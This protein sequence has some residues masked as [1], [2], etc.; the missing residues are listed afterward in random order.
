[1]SCEK[2][3]D[4]MIK[5]FAALPQA[6]KGRFHKTQSTTG[7]DDFQ[8]DRDRIVHS[9]AFR[10]LAH[11]TQV[12]VY[13]EGD[14]YRNRLTHSLEVAQITRAVARML[15]VNEDLAETTALAHDLGHPPFGHAGEDALDLNMK[16]FGGF[17]HNAQS[18]RTV[19][20]LEDRYPM[21]D[22][23]NLTIESLEG[24]LK[25]NGP[26]TDHELPWAITAFPFYKQLDLHLH[27]G[28]E[29]QI[30]AIC[31]DI[32]YNAHDIDDGLRAGM[33]DMAHL[34]ELE[35]CAKIMHGIKKDYPDIRPYPFKHEFIRRLIT[36]FVSDMVDHTQNLLDEY[37][38]ESYDAVRHA[39]FTFVSFSEEG[40][41]NNK[42]LKAYLM[43][44][45]YKHSIV[46]RMT[47]K[48]KRVISD[49]CKIYLAEPEIM[50]MN[51]AKNAQNISDTQRAV[52]I[53]DFIAGMTDKF[54]L[55]EHK[56]LFDL[57]ADNL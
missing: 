47:S 11:K 5:A 27:A 10:R 20:F 21:H 32:A 12:F 15:G 26:I 33:F 29:A 25:H 40:L 45:M 7:R 38:P 57:S 18:L 54:A 1:M 34:M 30:A 52:L 35:F 55:E 16:Q 24:I 6:T 36:Y 44:N 46:N 3:R 22:G 17:D 51:L 14:H 41:Q 39:G 50:P 8:R 19:T 56:K 31:D 28:I 48:A 43:Q 2:I 23:L 49:L 13:Y 37:K 9:K 4:L 42:A 53:T